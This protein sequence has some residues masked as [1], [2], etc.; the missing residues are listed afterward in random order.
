[1][2]SKKLSILSSKN[3]PKFNNLISPISSSSRP[4]TAKSNI[5][6]KFSIKSSKS[7]F[8]KEKK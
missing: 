6:A 8:D 4:F 1:M 2:H 7:N 5:S 3:S